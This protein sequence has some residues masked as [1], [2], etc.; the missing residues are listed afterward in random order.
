MLYVSATFVYRSTN[1]SKIRIVY[2]L[3][4]LWYTKLLFKI[5][6]GIV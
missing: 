6:I 1:R 2:G 4:N 5:K 3:H